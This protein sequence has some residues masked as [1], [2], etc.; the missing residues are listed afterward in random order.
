M[1]LDVSIFTKSE[2][3]YIHL[4][5]AQLKRTLIYLIPLF[6][7]KKT[8][9]NNAENFYGFSFKSFDHKPYLYMLLLMLPLIIIASF[10][11]SFQVSYPQFKP[12]QSNEIFHTN[13]LGLASIFELL[14]LL[15]FIMVELLFRGFIIIG[16]AK[17]L[18]K[19]AI[20]SPFGL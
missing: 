2:Y 15:D 19:D 20:L 17:L 7:I 3:K 13:K 16:L 9:D 11:E 10:Q 4:I 8:M 5:I 18:G 14:Y 6:I 1:F 12:W